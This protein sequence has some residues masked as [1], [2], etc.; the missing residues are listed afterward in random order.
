MKDLKEKGFNNLTSWSRGIDPLVFK[1]QIDRSFPKYILYVGRVSDEKNI[2]DFLK[3]D[4]NK[5]NINNEMLTKVV[6][7]DGPDL[8]K[9][10]K[11]SRMENLKDLK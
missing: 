2:R 11:Q 8:K 4:L 5:I 3:I 6:I 1:P 10:M 9:Y 7:G